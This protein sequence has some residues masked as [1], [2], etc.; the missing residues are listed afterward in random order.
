MWG[1][2]LP[3]VA[4]VVGAAVA[5]LFAAPS[6]RAA[7]EEIRLGST[8]LRMVRIERGT[9]HQGSPPGEPGR[10]ADEVVREVTIS[11]A[12]LLGET[13]ITRD[14]FAAFVLATGYKTEAERGAS[15]GEGWNGQ[16]LEQSPKYNWQ[17]PGFLQGGDH[18]V[19]LVTWNDADAYITWAA[20]TSGLILRLPREAELEYAT[21]AG[22]TSVWYTGETSPFALRGGWFDSEPGRTHPVKQ[23]AS[24]GWGLYD[25]MGAVYMW[26]AD[27]YAPYARG[28]GGPVADPFGVATDSPARKALRGG[29][30]MRGP[31]SGRSA[32]RHRATPGTRSAENGFRVAASLDFASPT[33]SSK[34]TS[35]PPSKATSAPPISPTS[36]STPTSESTTSGWLVVAL[37]VLFPLVVVGVLLWLVFRAVL[38]RGGGLRGRGPDGFY[39]R[40]T[41]YRA[42]TPLRWSARVGSETRTGSLDAVDGKDVFVYTGGHPEEVRVWAATS[43]SNDDDD[44]RDRTYEHGTGVQP[45]FIPQDQHHPTS[46]SSSDEPW[47]GGGGDFGGGGASSDYDDSGSSGSSG[48]GFPSAY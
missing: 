15:G 22:T 48:G 9:F 46:S 6:A 41:S 40:T 33:P 36:T 5:A 7:T 45:M 3:E 42:G 4:V 19:V 35:A 10:K 24:N 43:A 13:P 39:Y 47:G 44:D 31:A 16:K 25:M 26:C 17:S 28:E 37:A 32:A 8:T 21:R 11:S 27:D 14:Q 23:K 29:S 12:F 20:R 2:K 34:A 38:G 30:W 1:M 18:P